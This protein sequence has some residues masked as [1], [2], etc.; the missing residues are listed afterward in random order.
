MFKKFK[1]VQDKAENHYNKKLDI[2]K[3]NIVLCLLQQNATH[4][5]IAK[6]LKISETTVSFIKHNQRWNSVTGARFKKRVYT[7]TPRNRT[8]STDDI[9]FIRDNYKNN[10]MSQN[11]LAKLFNVSQPVV[12]DIVH[13]RTYRDLL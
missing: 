13:N 6:K 4:K 1:N 7:P 3:V 2:T 9:L 5:Y 11:Y 10:T 12:F 8:L